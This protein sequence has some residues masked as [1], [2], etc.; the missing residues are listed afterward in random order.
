ME[1]NSK[2]DLNTIQENGVVDK[3]NNNHILSGQ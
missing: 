2:R 1:V 3:L